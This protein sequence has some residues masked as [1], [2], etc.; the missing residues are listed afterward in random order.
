MQVLW[1]RLITITILTFID[2]DKGEGLDY[3]EQPIPTFPYHLPAHYSMFPLFYSAFSVTLLPVPR[4]SPVY[5]YPP[6]FR[7]IT[8]IYPGFLGANYY[9]ILLSL[10]SVAF[11]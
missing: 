1:R 7:A 5:V 4:C 3:L 6:E 8:L 11:F 10:G 2:L 9:P